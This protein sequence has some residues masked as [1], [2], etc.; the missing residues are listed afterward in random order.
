MG[1]PMR[2]SRSRLRVLK[3]THGKIIGRLSKPVLRR[4]AA[5]DIE[6]E[7]LKYTPRWCARRIKLVRWLN[8]RSWLPDPPPPLPPIPSQHWTT[9]ISHWFRDHMNRI[10]DILADAVCA[11]A[12]G[13]TPRL[14]VEDFI[15]AFNGRIAPIA[16]LYDFE[17]H[18]EKSGDK[19]VLRGDTG[20]ATSVLLYL[21][22]ERRTP[23]ID[24]LLDVVTMFGI[25][26]V[27]FDWKP[28]WDKKLR[29]TKRGRWWR[30]QRDEEAARF[31]ALF[32][33]R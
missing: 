33:N 18:V 16:E 26:R 15:V 11:A 4:L 14:E 23:E 8:R 1:E 29:H 31:K 2:L 12:V 3:A 28:T 19:V 21:C 25:S 7:K 24:W 17:L 27:P 20:K 10:A 30:K 22:R 5:I 9:K 6:I 32:P 13:H